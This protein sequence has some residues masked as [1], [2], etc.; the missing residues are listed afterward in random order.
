MGSTETLLERLID[1][2]VRVVDSRSPDT[3]ELLTGEEVA[4][5]V[6]MTAVATPERC[7]LRQRFVVVRVDPEVLFAFWALTSE[8]AILVNRNADA[9]ADSPVVFAEK[10]NT[11]RESEAIHQAVIMT[12][13]PDKHLAEVPR[14][15]IGPTRSNFRPNSRSQRVNNERSFVL[16]SVP[17]IANSLRVGE[18]AIN[19]HK[20]IL[21][22]SWP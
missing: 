21:M 4:V 15:T 8:I 9:E 14:L 18:P 16:L 7:L 20:P 5:I 19:W 1:K 17:K 3:F 12:P 10:L 22:Q 11:V 13:D 6:L 2:L